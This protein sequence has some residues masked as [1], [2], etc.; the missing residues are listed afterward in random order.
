[1][2]SVGTKSYRQ[3]ASDTVGFEAPAPHIVV[4]CPSCKT[5]FAVETAAVAALETPR[6]HC[7]RCDD[8]FIMKDAPADMLPLGGVNVQSLTHGGY[9]HRPPQSRVRGPVPESLIKPSDFSLGANTTAPKAFIEPNFDAPVEPS[10]ESR[11]ELSLLSRNVE[12]PQVEE[13]AIVDTVTFEA[14]AAPSIE[15]VSAPL[16]TPSPTTAFVVAPA[17]PAQPLSSRQFVLA[18]PTPTLPE[19]ALSQ[20]RAKAH[21]TPAKK[22]AST[23]PAATPTAR[24]VNETESYRLTPQPRRNETPNVRPSESQRFSIR[25]QSLISM[26]API[27]ASLAALLGLSYCAQ[28][29]PQ[30]VDALVQYVTP[31]VLKESAQSTPP[32]TLGVKNL[33]ISFKKTRNR[34][35]IPLITGTVTNESGRAFDD[36]E[37]EVIGFNGRGEIIASSR[38]PLRSA[39]DKENVSELSLETVA[40]SQQELAAKDSSIKAREA[41]PF[42]IALL[43][44]RQMDQGVDIAEFDPSQVKY[45]SARIFSVKRPR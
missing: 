26:G 30:S 33:R 18:D 41:V 8:I 45:F 32:S 29:S 43:N 10:A 13:S 37:L 5:S 2:E 19:H 7:S 27:L 22:P 6:F 16:Q 9:T 12:E 17:A 40:S 31:S 15:K 23:P 39:L 24:P 21:V 28:V 42:T 44:G 36:V 25:T 35:F 34:E 20:P 14:P 38:A 4:V 3:R 1:M 11:S